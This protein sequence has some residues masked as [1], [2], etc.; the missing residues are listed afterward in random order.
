M[1]GP[2]SMTLDPTVPRDAK[3][4]VQ[5]WTSSPTDLPLFA[6]HRQ[7]KNLVAAEVGLER[8]RELEGLAV[9]P[10]RRTGDVGSPEGLTRHSV[11]F[12][13]H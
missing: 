9:S 11:F 6:Y 1:I 2:E 3:L 12:L 4:S 13:V 5:L 10:G 7:S 8:R